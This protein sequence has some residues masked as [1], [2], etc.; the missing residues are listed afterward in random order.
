MENSR[1]SDGMVAPKIVKKKVKK[2]EEG[3]KID[4]KN[5]Y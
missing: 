5:L 4:N 1:R 2:H 3:A